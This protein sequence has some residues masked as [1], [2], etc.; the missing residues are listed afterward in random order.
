MTAKTRKYRLLQR[1]GEVDNE[2]IINKLEKLLNQLSEDNGTLAS[3]NKPMREKL[4]IE[5]LMK[6]QNYQHPSKR[7]LDSI[8]QEADI[9]EPIEDLLMMI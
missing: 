5:E 2:L 6:E 9:Q 1:I 4:D 7:E 3:L 8:I